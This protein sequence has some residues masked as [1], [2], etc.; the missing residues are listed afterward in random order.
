MIDV[1]ENIACTIL[2]GCLGF[3]ISCLMRISKEVEEDD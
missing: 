2:G 1:I 3:I